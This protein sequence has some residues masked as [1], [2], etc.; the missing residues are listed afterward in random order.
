MPKLFAD[1]LDQA[2]QG[3]RTDLR[4]IRHYCFL[5]YPDEGFYPCPSQAVCK[6]AKLISPMLS[7]GS[8]TFTNVAPV[9][10]TL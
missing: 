8:L 3:L 4:S 7:A 10:S 9:A 6:D 2:F 5:L 1:L